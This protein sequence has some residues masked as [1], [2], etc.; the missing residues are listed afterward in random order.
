MALPQEHFAGLQETPLCGSCGPWLCRG[1]F[2]A[3]CSSV[4]AF[5]RDSNVNPA[6]VLAA[7]SICSVQHFRRNT[8]RE[9][10]W[11]R[12]AVTFGAQNH[13]VKQSRWLTNQD[14]CP[15][16]PH[17]RGFEKTCNS[18]MHWI[19]PQCQQRTGFP[20]SVVPQGDWPH[21]RVTTCREPELGEKLPV[22]KYTSP[23]SLTVD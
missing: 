13:A 8:R 3:L 4:Y 1:S 17:P 23:S 22:Q 9:L 5:H 18:K 6:A 11:I 12:K 14:V 19:C 7:V 20:A 16:C 2:G 10:G 15:H 21:Y